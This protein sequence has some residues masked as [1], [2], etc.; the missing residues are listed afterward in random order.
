MCNEALPPKGEL[1][2]RLFSNRVTVLL[3]FFVN[4]G[5]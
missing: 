5:A 3:I 1:E 4:Q 2:G